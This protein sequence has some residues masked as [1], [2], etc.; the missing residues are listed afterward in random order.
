M[1]KD[2]SY[3]TLDNDFLD[4]FNKL[5]LKRDD[6][7]EHMSNID[8]EDFDDFFVSQDYQQW[9]MRKSE[10]DSDIRCMFDKID[11]DDFV[12]IISLGIEVLL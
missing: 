5:I 9:Q 8:D 1:N 10:V 12:E 4:T 7:I 3:L 6:C 11:T 2:I